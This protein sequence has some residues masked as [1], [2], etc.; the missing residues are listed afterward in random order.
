[1]KTGIFAFIVLTVIFSIDVLPKELHAGI[2]KNVAAHAV[3]V[4][5]N[6]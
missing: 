3:Y 6:A 5:S 2:Y 4:I 1:M